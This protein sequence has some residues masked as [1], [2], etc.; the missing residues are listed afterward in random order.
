M[1]LISNVS[2][3]HYCL[4]AIPNSI[5]RIQCRDECHFYSYSHQHALYNVC[6]F[7]AYHHNIRAK[8]FIDLVASDYLHNRYRF[9]LSYNLFS[10]SYSIRMLLSFVVRDPSS[11]YSLTKLYPAINW[12][13]REVWDLFGLPFLDHADMRRILT[14]YGLAG[15]PLKKDYPLSGF[16]EVHYDEH[17]KCIVYDDVHLVQDYRSWKFENPWSFYSDNA[18]ARDTNI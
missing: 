7:Y 17:Y 9:V 11:L 10:I 12:Y 1:A 15:H 2:L 13:E 3:V 5:F 8:L 4:A 16:V 14:D 18:M 6:L